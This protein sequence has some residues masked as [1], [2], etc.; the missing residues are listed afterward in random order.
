MRYCAEVK[1]APRGG[2]RRARHR[3]EIDPAFAAIVE[4]DLACGRHE[5][6]TENPSYFTDAYFHRPEELAGELAEAG[7]R[8]VRVLAVEG[9]LWLGRHFA[10][11]WNDPPM[12]ERMLDLLEKI[13]AEP[14]LQGASCHLM[15]VGLR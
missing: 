6:P 2:L 11:F 4:R 12:R 13:E 14:S 1:G 10:R 7:F 5:N 3:K 9:P 15:A 8:D